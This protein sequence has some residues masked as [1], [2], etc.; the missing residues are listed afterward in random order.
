MH[1]ALCLSPCTIGKLR[2]E[3]E[4]KSCLSDLV[5]LVCYSGLDIPLPLPRNYY[6]SLLILVKPAL[7][8]NRICFDCYLL[9]CDVSTPGLSLRNQP[10][11][12]PLVSLSSEIHHPDARAFWRL[13]HSFSDE[14]F[15]FPALATSVLDREKMQLRF[16][17]FVLRLDRNPCHSLLI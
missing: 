1:K 6:L 8:Y 9:K 5:N 7:F 12:L 13:G 17:S 15:N 4:I 10:T 11:G 2:Q 3:T 14:A 16:R